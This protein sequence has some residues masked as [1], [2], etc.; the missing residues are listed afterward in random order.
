MKFPPIQ[1]CIDLDIQQTEEKD[2]TKTFEPQTTETDEK[3]YEAQLLPTLEISPI[4][5]VPATNDVELTRAPTWNKRRV[6]GY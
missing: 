4:K 3:S 6:K 5:D 1:L 2:L